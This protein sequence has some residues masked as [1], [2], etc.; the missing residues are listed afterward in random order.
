M[1][2]D[3]VGPSPPA[4]GGETSAFTQK[5]K[6]T[7]YPGAEG[8]MEVSGEAVTNAFTDCNRGC[9][10]RI[11]RLRTD[12]ASCFLAV[13]FVTMLRKR[14]IKH[15]HATREKPQTNS[16]IERFHLT[17][18]GGTRAQLALSRLPY[19]FWLLSL[20]HWLFNYARLPS[21]ITDIQGLNYV[22]AEMTGLTVSGN[23]AM[24]ALFSDMDPFGGTAD[25]YFDDLLYSGDMDH[26]AFVAFAGN[27]TA[28]GT[29]ADFS[30]WFDPEVDE[31]QAGYPSPDPRH[32]DRF[33]GCQVFSCPKAAMMAARSAMAGVEEPKPLKSSLKR[34]AVSPWEKRFMKE[35]RGSR[36]VP[37]G[38][39]AT[40][41][42]ISDGTRGNLPGHRK[43]DATGRRGAIVGYG[44]LRS[45]LVMDLQSYLTE[46]IMVFRI[47]RDVRVFPGVFDLPAVDSMSMQ[48]SLGAVSAVF[49][50]S[51]EA[52]QAF[53]TMDAEEKSR[54]FDRGD[55]RCSVFA[56]YI[57]YGKRVTCPPCNGNRGNHR[58][59]A[60]CYRGRCQGHDLPPQGWAPSGSS[61]SQGPQPPPAP[62]PLGP[63]QYPALPPA[64]ANAAEVWFDAEDGTAPGQIVN[65]NAV[66]P[67]AASPEQGATQRTLQRLG[68]LVGRGVGSAAG[69]P[70]SAPAIFGEAVGATIGEG[71]GGAAGDL[72]SALRNRM[73]PTAP[74]P[75]SGGASSSSGHTGPPPPPP[76]GAAGMAS[77]VQNATD[78]WANCLTDEAEPIAGL[79]LG[80]RLRIRS[81]L[82]DK[83]LGLL[84]EQNKSAFVAAMKSLYDNGTA[85]KLRDHV[86]KLG[87][88]QYDKA[89]WLE[90]IES[91]YEPKQKRGTI[92]FP[93]GY[94][95]ISRAIPRSSPEFSSGPAA[96]ALEKEI[97][98]LLERKCFSWHAVREASEIRR[99]HPQAQFIRLHPIM[100]VKNAELGAKLEQ[101]KA[102]IVAGGNN[103]VDGSGKKV[104]P[105][106]S[107]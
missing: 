71:I 17:A 78:W 85:E 3:T 27:C 80:L 36:L 21:R 74:T 77:E 7:G 28:N 48:R 92:Y 2:A 54:A 82:K 18:E 29:A 19:A 76:G 83:A 96:A 101:Y 56:K 89:E 59:N 69:P 13:I 12:N 9:M 67:A 42:H 4:L 99:L 16:D 1:S 84:R 103:I 90:M 100:V 102:R 79:D 58:S 106:G 46:G 62:G 33:M 72:V 75:G 31:L 63:A 39:R 97:D 86:G 91:V 95:L 57:P 55:G 43:W 98:S 25:E 44:P 68:E 66:A 35:Y 30:T 65:V 24:G 73:S 61:G 37:F 10:H 45:Y 105:D 41:L 52:A 87:E 94:A 6:A 50:K 23:A 40:F 32:Y 15:D 49:K 34:P 93:K 107:T 60:S 53:L 81:L 51:R 11:Q 20:L 38:C 26:A 14:N 70:G 104:D 88:N 22:P 5:D 64:P 8:L 47:T